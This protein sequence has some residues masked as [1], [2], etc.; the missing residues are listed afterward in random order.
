MVHNPDPGDWFA[1]FDQLPPHP[2]PKKR[3]GKKRSHG[4]AN[5]DELEE[6]F[7]F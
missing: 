7:G 2:H 6:M 1:D 3:K 4:G 5:F